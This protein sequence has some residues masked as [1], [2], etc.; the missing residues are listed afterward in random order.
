MEIPRNLR[1]YAEVV[2]DV[3]TGVAHRPATFQTVIGHRGRW[4]REAEE[5]V[6]EPVYGLGWYPRC[7]TAPGPDDPA[8]KIVHHSAGWAAHLGYDGCPACW[9]TDDGV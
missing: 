6:Q 2:V 7:A 8:P 9:P 4:D 3:G 5:M 1:A